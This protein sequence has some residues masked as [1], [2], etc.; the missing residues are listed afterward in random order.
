MLKELE[1]TSWDSAFGPD[2]AT[3]DSPQ[4]TVPGDRVSLD[5]ILLEDVIKIKHIREG[6]NDGD[7]WLLVGEVKD[8]RWFFLSAWCD[9]TGWG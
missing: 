8:G 3:A 7:P 2:G 9:Y 6:E 1:N 4:A 5:P